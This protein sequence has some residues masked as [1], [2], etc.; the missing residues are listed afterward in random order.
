MKLK[1]SYKFRYPV[2]D[3]SMNIIWKEKFMFKESFKLGIAIRTTN[4]MLET[5]GY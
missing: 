1:H 5:Q 2:I 3:G 4:A